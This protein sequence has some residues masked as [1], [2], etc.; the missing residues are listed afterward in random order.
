MRRLYKWLPAA[1]L[2]LAEVM[3][4]GTFARAQAPPKPNENWLLD[5][6]DDSE[7]FKR[8]Q[9]MFGGFSAAMLVVGERYDRTYD[10]IAEDNF[11]LADY[12]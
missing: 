4:S 3:V 10:A 9:Q 1:F 8:I 2:V 11:A 6:G 12:H 7:R 5:A